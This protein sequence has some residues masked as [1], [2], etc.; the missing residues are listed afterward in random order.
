MSAMYAFLRGSSSILLLTLCFGVC[1][2]ASADPAP[3][4]A[5]ASKV[6]DY[7]PRDKKKN[8]GR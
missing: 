2:V 5:A 3:A 7:T 6:P 8:K 1:T 4:A